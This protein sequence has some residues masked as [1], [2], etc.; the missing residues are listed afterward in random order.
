MKAIFSILTILVSSLSYAGG[1]YYTPNQNNYQDEAPA[2]I[3]QCKI[4]LKG[5]PSSY[6]Y[7]DYGS[8]GKPQ[9][10]QKVYTIRLKEKGNGLARAVFSTDLTPSYIY[11]LVVKADGRVALRTQHVSGQIV[12]QNKANSCNNA[13]VNKF[14]TKDCGTVVIACKVKKIEQVIEEPIYQQEKPSCGYNQNGC[15][16]TPKYQ[17]QQ[18]DMGDEL[19]LPE[20]DNIPADKQ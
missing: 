20:E 6:S 10:I 14:D 15:Y 13:I 8:Y 3:A 1:S 5:M 9:V 4:V 12:T 2:A 17:E 7:S 16:Q 18:T 19:P 11:D